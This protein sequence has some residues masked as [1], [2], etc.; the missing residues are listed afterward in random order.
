MAQETEVITQEMLAGPELLRCLRLFV[1]AVGD[2][3][4]GDASS[5]LCTAWRESNRVLEKLKR[6]E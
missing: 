4:V 1:W 5:E 2:L 3:R 6:G